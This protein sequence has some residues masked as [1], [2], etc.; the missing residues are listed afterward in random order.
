MDT[1]DDDFG[2]D[3]DPLPFPYPLGDPALVP[4]ARLMDLGVL[5]EDIDTVRGIRDGDDLL[6]AMER[7]G[8]LPQ[9]E[10]MCLFDDPTLPR[11]DALLR[12]RAKHGL[13]AKGDDVDG[14]KPEELDY[15]RAASLE[16]FRRWFSPDQRDAVIAR[17]PGPLVV[18]GAAGTGKTVVALHRANYLARAVFNGPGDRLLLT[19]FSRTLA[20]DL[21]RQLDE[22]CTDDPGAR[23]RI[24]VRNV[25]DAM[26][27]FLNAN[28]VEMA[29]EFDKFN[30]RVA[31]LMRRASREANYKGERRPGWLW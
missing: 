14:G 27:A 20:Q 23:A 10:L 2:A 4:D 19:T 21:G 3:D 11:L 9:H 25:D 6:D 26:V 31:D 29:M 12:N 13:I 7:H 8:S 15:W 30:D 17:A 18:L 28:G 24:D 22:I 5:H 16:R 1:A